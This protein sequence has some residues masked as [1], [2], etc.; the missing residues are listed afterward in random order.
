[1]RN[2]LV[3]DAGVEPALPEY[4]TGALPPKL[5]QR[6]GAVSRVRTCGLSHTKRMLYHLSYDS[7]ED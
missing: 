2:R 6:N 3:L 5:I 1:M 7:V 4:E